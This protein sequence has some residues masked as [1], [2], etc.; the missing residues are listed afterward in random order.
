M[1]HDFNEMISKSSNT[2]YDF[3]KHLNCVVTASSYISV[4]T[5]IDIQ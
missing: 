4:Q 1:T 3:L 5:K 2:M